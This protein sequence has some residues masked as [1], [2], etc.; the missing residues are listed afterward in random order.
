MEK[1]PKEHSKEPSLPVDIPS[2]PE[3]S[4]LLLGEEIEILGEPHLVGDQRVLLDLHSVINL[5]N[6]ILGSLELLDHPDPELGAEIAEMTAQIHEAAL[7]GIT[8]DLN[9]KLPELWKARLQSA[10]AKQGPPPTGEAARDRRELQQ[11]LF[12]V[13]DIFSIR[14]AE[15][16]ERK[17]LPDGWASFTP[18]KLK[19]SILQVLAA[20]EKNAHG[21]YRIVHNI[22]EQSPLD[23]Q[24][25][26]AVTSTITPEFMMPAALQDVLRDLIANARKYTP[27]GGKIT[28]GVHA[29]REGIRLVVEDNG[30]GIPLAELRKVVEFGYR[31]SNAA[32]KRTLGGGFGLTKA[33]SVTKSFGG[34]MWLRSRENLGTRVT[35]FI[36][37]RKERIA[38]PS[39]I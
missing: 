29:S 1:S 17:L 5:L 27:L 28:A 33:W 4:P 14:A 35:L 22:A 24:V 21:R 31:A 8:P 9:P 12:S 15:L 25:D 19:S 11:T 6:V 10:L 32:G 2:A 18:Q 38:S 3:Q 34:R 20:I 37:A 13:L 16:A 36:P 23:Y 7:L 39:A 26:L 30:M